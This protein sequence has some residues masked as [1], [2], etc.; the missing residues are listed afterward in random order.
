MSAMPTTTRSAWASCWP[1]CRPAPRAWVQAAQELPSRTS[2][3]R[4]DRRARPCRRGFS[5]QAPRGSRGRA[6]LGGLRAQRA[7]RGR[8]AGTPR[9]A[10]LEMSLYTGPLRT[11][12]DE[13]AGPSPA[14]GA[15][16]VSGVVTA[17]AAGLI[18]SAARRSTEWEEG[19]GVVRTGAGA[20]LPGREARG[21]ER[22]GL[23]RGARADRERRRRRRP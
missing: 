8:A 18:A 15:G 23:P 14:P 10:R 3:A 21:G 4:R 13:I 17:M 11:V 1:S 16:A 12:L 7:P 20:P 5:R 22:G 2:R 19:R 6:R 9:R